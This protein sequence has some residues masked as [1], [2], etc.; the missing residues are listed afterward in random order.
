MVIV[1]EKEAAEG[2]V[3]MRKQGGGEQATM[4]MQEFADRVNGEVAQMLEAT[5]IEPQ[6]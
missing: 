4:T 5:N 1:G 6:D 2:L 3:S